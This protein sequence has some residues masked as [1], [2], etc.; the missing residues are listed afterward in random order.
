MGGTLPPSLSSHRQHSPATG[1]A[2]PKRAVHDSV[3][4]VGHKLPPPRATELGMNI[5]AKIYGGVFAAEDP[6]LKAKKPKGAKAESLGS[7]AVPRETRRASNS[8]AED[9]HRLAEERA[10]LTYCG[11]DIQVELVNFSAAAAP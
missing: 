7:V 4:K 2:G 5:R 8:R 11:R 6:L 9:R 1:I 10:R 3:T